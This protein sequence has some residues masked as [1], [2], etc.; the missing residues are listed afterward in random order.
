MYGLEGVVH[1]ASR[2][3]SVG[4]HRDSESNSFRNNVEPTGGAVADARFPHPAHRN[5]QAVFRHPAPGQDLT[6]SPTGSSWDDRS[7]GPTATHRAG[8]D[9]GIVRSPTLQ[10]VLAP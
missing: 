10:L 9:R 7:S 6:L 2:S 1:P 8:A 3:I 4:H 5:G